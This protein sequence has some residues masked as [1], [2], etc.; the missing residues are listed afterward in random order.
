MVRIAM[1]EDDLSQ[2][3]RLREYLERFSAETGTE[4]TVDEF[5]DGAKLLF[6]YRPIY[7]IILL[8]I[9]MPLMDGMEAAREIRKQDADAVIIFITNMA[10]YAIQGYKVRA[11][12]YL[13]KPVSYYGLF[14]ELREA[15]DTV[16]KRGSKSSLL[17]SVGGETVKIPVNEIR[18]IE[19]QKHNLIIHTT[20]ENYVLRETM[21]NMCDKLEGES[22]ALSGVSY[23]VNLSHVTSVG[24]TDALLGKELIPISR[25]KHK[26]F[27]DALAA[28][29]G[30]GRK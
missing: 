20:V 11:Q 3:R 19:S 2:A 8:D 18:Y 6:D 21:K 1:A 15:I 24:K 12:S 4:L 10:Q 26:S 23:L 25:Q 29:V 30:S 22:F 28:Y 7:D 16:K 13:L 5:Q 17:I 14:P 9:E 27:L